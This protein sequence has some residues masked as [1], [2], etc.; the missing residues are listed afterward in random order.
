MSNECA[1]EEMRG[2]IAFS[3]E[4]VERSRSFDYSELRVQ[5]SAPLSASVPVP[6]HTL[7]QTRVVRVLRTLPLYQAA[8]LRYAYA[9]RD[10]LDEWDDLASVA[11]HVFEA[12]VA[13]MSELTPEKKTRL[14]GFVL[15]A[16]Q[17]VRHEMNTGNR[18]YTT[19]KLIELTQSTANATQSCWKRDWA[20]FWK[21]LCLALRI[22]DRQGLEATV[23]EYRKESLYAKAQKRLYANAEMRLSA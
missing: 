11:C 23:T 22:M 13:Q 3:F 21:A 19:A 1:L 12:C 5:T 4:H 8:W 14:Q 15:P 17:H 2:L 16:L 7:S 9:H 18:L 10:A 6:S 20:P